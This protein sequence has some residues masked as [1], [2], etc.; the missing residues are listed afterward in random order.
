[1][2]SLPALDDIR[3][4]RAKRHYYN[5]VK[6]VHGPMYKYTRHGEFICNILDAAVKKRQA[7]LRGE[8]P[9]K[10][11]YIKFSM[12]PQHGKSMH[13]TETFPSYFLG[14][15]KT[16]GVIEISYN[17]DFASKFGSRNRDKIKEHGSELFD[18]N[19]AKDTNAK[20]EW[21]V[22]EAS[23][24]KKTRGG[25]ISRG[26]LGGVTGSSLGDCIIIDDPIKNREEANSETTRE[27]IWAEWQ[28]SI[29]TRIHPGAIVILIM[30]RWHEDDLWGRLDSVEHGKPLPWENYNLPLEA[31]ANDLLGR[32]IGE[33]LWPDKYGL[34]FIQER[35]RYSQSFNSL[36]QG[37][38]TAAE[39]NMIKK[40]WWQYYTE[41][42]KQFDEMLQSWDLTFKD[43]DG[44]DYVVGQVWGRINADKYL[45]DQVR[46]R[47]N[48]TDSVKA[49]EAVSAKYPKAR[50]KLIEDKANGSAVINVLQHKLGGIVA[51][52]PKESKIARASAV[53]TD[54]EAGNV[55]L[56]KFAEFTKGLVEEAAA[57]PNGAHDDQVDATTQ[58]LNRMIFHTTEAQKPQVPK[59]LPEDLRRDLEADPVALEHYLKI[60]GYKV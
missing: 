58:A 27:K 45:I 25:M 55:Y 43:S 3:K 50:L 32:Q 17:D 42:P 19:I 6:Y 33:A 10:T 2:I 11:Q 21:D 47:M 51:I 23:T 5:Y 14:K 29:S 38:P 24:G 28:D 37:R 7:M 9:V 57:F 8:I 49:V 13:I 35:K 46:G 53:S 1:M 4:E 12:P 54:I 48:F 34:D 40:A 59:D 52:T 44:S 36:Y 60:H 39:G 26:I 22:L 20:G 56:P 15:F 16:E 30:T 41:L 18:I 31:E